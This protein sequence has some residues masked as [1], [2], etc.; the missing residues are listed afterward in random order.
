MYIEFQKWK[1]SSIGIIYKNLENYIS[2]YDN[3]IINLNL[4]KED[5]NDFNLFKD[6]DYNECNINDV[7]EKM[8]K[9]NINY[10]NNINNFFFR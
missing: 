9:I 7:N 6:D 8:N 2:S 1:T 3:K 5:S 10:S 4:I